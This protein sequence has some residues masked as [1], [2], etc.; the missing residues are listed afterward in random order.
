M[1][2]Y[3]SLSKEDYRIY[4]KYKAEEYLKSSYWTDK[5][6]GLFMKFYDLY[7]NKWLKANAFEKT[8]VWFNETIIENI[9]T[10]FITADSNTTSSF[11][12]TVSFLLS[13]DSSFRDLED[14]SK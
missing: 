11:S 2:K 14:A 12:E 7:I 8:G 3:R 5:T 1:H 9:R 6:R 4:I 13:I 10:Y